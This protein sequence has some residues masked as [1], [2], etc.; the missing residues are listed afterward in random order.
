[1]VYGAY[2][3][4]AGRA[5]RMTGKAV[6]GGKNREGL[7]AAV[8]RLHLTGH[9]TGIAADKALA[10]HLP[11][12][13]DEGNGEFLSAHGSTGNNLCCQGAAGC[14][15]T[16]HRHEA[17]GSERCCDLKKASPFQQGISIVN[18]SLRKEIS[19]RDIASKKRVP[20]TTTKIKESLTIA[21]RKAKV[22]SLAI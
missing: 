1:M 9:L 4:R 3:D 5:L 12:N 2:I 10:G 17:G 13:L 20:N 15:N 22:F 14:K 19:I 7:P 21:S 6:A 8:Q 16:R 18:T 11:Q